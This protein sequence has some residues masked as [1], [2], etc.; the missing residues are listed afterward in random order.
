VK[1]KREPGI[2][3]EVAMTDSH[4]IHKNMQ[5]YSV[6]RKHLGHVANIYEDSFLVQKGFF[7]HSDRYIPYSAILR[8]EADQI[9][10]TMNADE[11]QDQEWEIRPNYEA[12]LG[13]PTQLFYDRGHGVH[14]PFDEQSPETQ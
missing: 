10:L 6:D 1:A 14:D 4:D 2:S 3:G 7:F 13:D 5:V 9:Q 8:V 11:A 12:H